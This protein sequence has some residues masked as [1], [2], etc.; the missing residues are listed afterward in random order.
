[1]NAPLILVQLLP[2]YFFQSK[3]NINKNK[4]GI[5]ILTKDWNK[6]V[7]NYVYKITEIGYK[8]FS[9]KSNKKKENTSAFGNLWKN[10]CPITVTW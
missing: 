6:T 7:E 3:E 9:I 8:T 1:M 5:F 10:N 4:I 2:E